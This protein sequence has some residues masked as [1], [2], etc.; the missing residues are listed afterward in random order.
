MVHYDVIHL[1]YQA[2][3][4]HINMAINNTVTLTHITCYD[5]NLYCDF[6]INDL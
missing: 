3:T 2:N 1:N 5:L 4:G 6:D